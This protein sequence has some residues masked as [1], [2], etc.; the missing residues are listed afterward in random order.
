MARPAPL[1]A[2][3]A[4]EPALP[5]PGKGLA[6]G[7]PVLAPDAVGSCR[8]PVRALPFLCACCHCGRGRLR[9]PV[10]VPAAL[11]RLGSARADRARRGKNRPQRMRR[12]RAPPPPV[13]PASRWREQPR[14]EPREPGPQRA[15]GGAH[16]PAPPPPSSR[17]EKELP[18]AP[19]RPGAEAVGRL[20]IAIRS[21][22][23]GREE[24][25]PA[26][27]G[28]PAPA[29]S[30]VPGLR[31]PG[32]G[33]GS[34][35]WGQPV[36]C[37]R[38][39]VP[40]PRCPDRRGPVPVR[41]EGVRG[42]PVPRRPRAPPGRTDRR[43]ARGCGRGEQLDVAGEGEG[44][45][46]HPA[47]G[48]YR[49][50]SCPG[51]GSSGAPQPAL[52]GRL[53]PRRTGVGAGWGAGGG[54]C[55]S[56]G[57]AGGRVALAA[58]R[59]SP[60]PAPAPPPH[61]PPR[62]RSHGPGSASL[63]RGR[64]AVE[65][66]GRGL[67]GRR[68]PGTAGCGDVP[69]GDSRL[70]A[71]LPRVKFPEPRSRDSRSPGWSPADGHGPRWGSGARDRGRPGGARGP[72]TP[73][74]RRQRQLPQRDPARPVRRRPPPSDGTGL[75]RP[76][77]RR[78]GAEPSRTGPDW[79]FALAPRGRSWP[80]PGCA[81]PGFPRRSQRGGPGSPAPR[82]L[83]RDAAGRRRRGTRLPPGC[84]AGPGSPVRGGA[85]SVEPSACG[86]PASSASHLLP[87]PCRVPRLRE[88]RAGPG[89]SSR[90]RPG[91]GG[92]GFT[93][94]VTLS[95][96]RLQAAAAPKPH[97]F[98]PQAALFSF[99]RGFFPLGKCLFRH[100]VG[101]CCP[102]IIAESLLGLWGEVRVA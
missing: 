15:P 13:P 100:G 4:A 26:P 77:S 83:P 14:N 38:G 37:G 70:L 22:G 88:G 80:L 11:A 40:T 96:Q 6:G 30:S 94:E 73:R 19:H 50:R 32:R 76:R 78:R 16:R 58:P 85:S 27:P 98:H 36:T 48:T 34:R 69:S 54:Y 39:T 23:A 97:L 25:A 60:C 56:P 81:G 59:A 3:A 63:G 90:R 61:R 5:D 41:G 57:S 84:P 1:S 64:E 45:R 71:P 72:E 89:V 65:G 47:P 55:L 93:L 79:T 24:Q 102:K 29:S 33:A 66:A 75:A 62:G 42:T 46:G 68:E 2:P 87:R 7:H 18:A 95:A 53:Q 21:L 43:T 10:P 91:A 17:A 99:N 74:D 20:V 28:Y 49:L 52:P 92:R 82:P 44:E 35:P 31:L 67:G 51:A 86:P 9:D 8:S 101:D 12:R